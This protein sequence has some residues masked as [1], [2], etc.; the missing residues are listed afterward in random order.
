MRSILMLSAALLFTSVTSAS[1]APGCAI[2]GY[3]SQFGTDSTAHI[4]VRS[5]KFCARTITT[6][7][8]AIRV[9]I[10]A[11]PARYG[12][13]TVSSNNHWEYHARQGY[14]GK[15]EFV[16]RATGQAVRRSGYTDNGH[17]NVRVDVDVIP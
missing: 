13:A 17:S 10:I 14:I 11:Q 4:T 7:W 8:G 12:V 15:D 1:S 2:D 16:F 9:L 6:V 5:G 3:R